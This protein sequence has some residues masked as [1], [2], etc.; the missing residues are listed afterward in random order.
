MNG[1]VTPGGRTGKIEVAAVTVDGLADRSGAPD[2]IFIDVEGYEAQ[3]LA[4]ARNTLE[5]R[6][7]DFFVEVHEAQ[8]LAEA[9]ASA[10]EVVN[11][12]QANGYRCVAATA[13][14]GDV[15]GEWQDI[16]DAKPMAGRRSF[17]IAIP[18]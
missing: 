16:T 12:F 10:D 7:S 15:D 3:V 9:G 18:S 11:A 6:S 14:H 17:L 4:G 5:Q 13:T 1:S 2:V 8:T